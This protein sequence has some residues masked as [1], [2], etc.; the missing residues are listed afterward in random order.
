MHAG[1]RSVMSKKA[2]YFVPE[3]NLVRVDKWKDIPVWCAGLVIIAG[4]TALTGWCFDISSLKGFLSDGTAMSVNTAHL[5]I[6][7]GICLLLLQSEYVQ[8]ARILLTIILLFAL[9]IVYENISDTNFYI[10]QS[11]IPHYLGDAKA[12]GTGRTPLLM[13]L[14]TVLGSTAMLLSSYKRYYTAQ[15]I[16]S[17]LI[18][19]IYISILGTLFH[20]LGSLVSTGVVG[21][22]F[23][24]T[25]SLLLL[26][27]GTILLAPGEGWILLTLILSCISLV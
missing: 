8:A 12:V 9:A 21:T 5:L 2:A 13:A 22:A 17:T 18:I 19:L 10:D 4:L 26:A 3:S 15:F 23:N 16:S 7:S 24:T 14:Y 6:L 1:D 27:V 25:A 11:P 20:F